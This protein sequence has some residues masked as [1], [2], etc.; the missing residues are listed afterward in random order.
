MALFRKRPDR[1][2]GIAGSLDGKTVLVADGTAGGG[3]GVVRVAAE[4]GASTVFA[5]PNSITV[6]LQLRPLANTP[7]NVV[8]VV[9][10]ADTDRERARLIATPERFPDIV[11]VNAT[12]LT[13]EGSQTEGEGSTDRPGIAPQSAVILAR[14]AAVGMQDRGLTGNIVFLTEIDRSGPAAAAASYL[15]SEMEQLARQ[16]AANGIRVNAVAA[17][18]IALNR[19]GNVVSSRVAPLGHSSLHPVEVG[20]AAWF[21]MN[22]DLSG[23]VTGSVLRVDRGAALLRPEW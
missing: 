21:L 13:L 14:L 5:G 3:P 4:A 7:G 11:V 12:S 9:S 15:H 23:G 2:R 8:A 16:V 18:H 19:R 17:G 22:D 20:K 1:I 6:D 10:A